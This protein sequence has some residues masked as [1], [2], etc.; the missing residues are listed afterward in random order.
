MKKIFKLFC[1][2]MIITGIIMIP[3]NISQGNDSIEF[4]AAGICVILLFG[5][6]FV[7]L[8][9]K[10]KNENENITSN[11]D[12][13]TNDAKTTSEYLQ[14]DIDD[15]ELN[16]LEKQFVS[17]LMN[18]LNVL[19]INDISY[20][21][22]SN[23]C[24][25]FTYNDMQFGRIKLNGKKMWM[26]LIYKDDVKILD[27]NNIDEAKVHIKKWINYINYLK[28]DNDE[29]EE[30]NYGS[31]IKTSFDINEPIENVVRCPKCGSTSVITTN[32][33]LSVKR[34]VAGTVLINPV[35]G[36]V[37]AVTSKKMYNVCQK[38]GYRWKLK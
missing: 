7:K 18:T 5:F 27:I 25:N 22:M 4:I 8:N 3:V 19:G 13:Q 28:N 9:I 16:E 15:N 14:N 32:K 29:I 6:C 37:G 10:P 20:N 30:H 11:H 21:R 26:Q 34:A 17:D 38:C 1:L 2:S 12:Q 23:K 36:A 31:S 35:A 24:L 33:K